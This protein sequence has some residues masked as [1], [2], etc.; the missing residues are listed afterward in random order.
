MRVLEIHSLDD[1]KYLIRA[2]RKRQG[3]LQ[4]E[5]AEKACVSDR[6][7]STAETGRFMPHLE[8]LLDIFRA[9][10]YDEVHFKLRK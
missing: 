4:W 3:L 10:G 6:T 8:V 9:L 7:V 1:V 2:E 5:L